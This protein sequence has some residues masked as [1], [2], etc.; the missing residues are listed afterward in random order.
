MGAPVI[1][2]DNEMQAPT[3]GDTDSASN[4]FLA[5]LKPLL[6]SKSLTA[7]ND[8]DSPQS[9]SLQWLL[10]KSNFQEWSFPRQVQRYAMATFY[11][12]TGAVLSWS[13][14]QTWLT[15]ETECLWFQGSR[16]GGIC[17]KNGTAL[18]SLERNNNGLN[19]TIPDEIGLLTSLTLL[20]LHG[21]QFSGT[22]PLELGS[23]T[24]L[25]SLYLSRNAFTGTLPSQLGSLSDLT[26]LSLNESAFRGTLPSELGSLTALTKLVL[27]SND[28][29]G[30][31]PSEFGSLT[32]LTYLDFSA[33]NINGS[34]VPEKLCNLGRTVF[35]TVT[36]APSPL[37]SCCGC[38]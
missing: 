4:T 1:L 9:Q 17:G 36:C 27:Y 25:T 7:L 15:N 26:S 11:Y 30:N 3:K 5:K 19:G 16:G 38:C 18:H 29:Q 32:A 21:N 6:S 13:N 22:V 14:D 31:V 33:T 12:A 2:L 20:D 8:P 35:I 10:E 23:L 37:C 28:I 24:A 34:T